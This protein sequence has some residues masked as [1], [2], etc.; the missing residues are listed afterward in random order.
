MEWV[1]ACYRMLCSLYI[2]QV[3]ERLAKSQ[4]AQTAIAKT[5]GRNSARLSSPPPPPPQTGL[6][7]LFMLFTVAQ[8]LPFDF[9]IHLF[10]K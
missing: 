6:R 5:E 8:K 9:L 2:P 1:G 7:L 4:A 10:S 3:Q